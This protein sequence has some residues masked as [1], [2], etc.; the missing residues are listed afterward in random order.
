VFNYSIKYFIKYMCNRSVCW[1]STWQLV[2]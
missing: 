2:W 1:I